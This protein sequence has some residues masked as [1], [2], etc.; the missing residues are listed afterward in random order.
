M[1]K[2]LIKKIDEFCDKSEFP[3]SVYYSETIPDSRY[4]K[5]K[6]FFK[7]HNTHTVAK[8][9]RTQK[10]IEEFLNDSVL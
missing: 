4:K 7:Y 6:Y 9:F 3:F 10:E 1:K 5:Y 2:T 8:A